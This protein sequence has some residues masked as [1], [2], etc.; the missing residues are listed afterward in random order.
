MPA[1][2]RVFYSKLP[3]CMPMYA[4]YE[5]YES[6]LKSFCDWPIGLN[7]TDTDMATAGFFY[8]GFNDK[9][10]CYH[11]GMEHNRWLKNDVPKIMHAKIAGNRCYFAQLS[12]GQRFIR[13]V[14]LH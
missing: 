12:W 4:K 9:V 14:S 7:Q 13:S 8:T 2:E 11:C 5:T 6:R 10:Q 1:L 3:H